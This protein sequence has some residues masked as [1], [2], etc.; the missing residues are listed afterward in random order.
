MFLYDAKKKNASSPFFDFLS[1]WAPCCY[2]Y[3]KVIVLYTRRYAFFHFFLA[4]T[5]RHFNTVL[6]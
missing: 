3:Q 5:Q 6:C 4:M 2:F 1:S